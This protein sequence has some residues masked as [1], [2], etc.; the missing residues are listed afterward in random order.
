MLS[1]PARLSHKSP[2]L[3]LPLRSLLPVLNAVVVD[4]QVCGSHAHMSCSK[5]AHK[6]GLACKAL[7]KADVE[8]S[9]KRLY[10]PLVRFSSCLRLWS[11]VA[12]VFDHVVIVF[13]F[14][15]RSADLIAGF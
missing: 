5:R 8:V 14:S 12:V 15:Q 11:Y 13:L 6:E 10:R 7:C 4:L 9:H 3:F 1:F 2:C